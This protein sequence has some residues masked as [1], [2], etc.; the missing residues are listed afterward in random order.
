MRH[1]HITVGYRAKKLCTTLR[2]VVHPPRRGWGWV[3]R[4]AGD[5][6]L[7]PLRVA[8]ALALE[9]RREQGKSQKH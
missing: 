7:V 2:G 1:M 3:S 9:D 6:A 4:P 8:L 5:R